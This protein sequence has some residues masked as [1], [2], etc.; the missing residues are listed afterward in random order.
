MWGNNWMSGWMFNNP[1][2][3]WIVGPLALLDLV[4]KGFALWRAAK[5]GQ[6]VWF[7]ALLVV[8]SLGI[9][10]AIYLLLNK[11]FTLGKKVLKKK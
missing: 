9:L 10:P 7:I 1:R 8:N 5:R 11:D 3:L 4:L 6:Q 2:I